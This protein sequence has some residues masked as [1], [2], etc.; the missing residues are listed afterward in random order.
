METGNIYA[1][2]YSFKHDPLDY[3]VY[4]YIK[5]EENNFTISRIVK[6]YFSISISRIPYFII[7]VKFSNISEITSILSNRFNNQK[8]LLETFIVKEV[9]VIWKNPQEYSQFQ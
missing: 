6:N 5:G 1:L 9:K 3:L 7:K 2:I 4:F 8:E